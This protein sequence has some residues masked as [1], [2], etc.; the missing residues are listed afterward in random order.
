MVQGSAES[1]GHDSIS[2]LRPEP[3]RAIVHVDP[4]WTWCG[5]VCFHCLPDLVSVFQLEFR[6]LRDRFKFH[7]SRVPAS[8]ST[9]LLSSIMESLHLTKNTLIDWS[10]LPQVN[11]VSNLEDNVEV[12]MVKVRE[13]WQREE[14][15][16][17]QEEE[18]KVKWQRQ[19]EVSQRLGVR[20]GGANSM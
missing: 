11:L 18:A 17:R 15:M 13:Q 20:C 14:E 9:C 19:K 4:A 1:W 16:K 12:A 7:S 10:L 2:P 5:T 8:F 6:L 3:L